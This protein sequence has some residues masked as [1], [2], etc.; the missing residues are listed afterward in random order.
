[1]IQLRWSN[2]SEDGR[3]SYVM[4]KTDKVRDLVLIRQ[5]RDILDEYDGEHGKDDYIFPFL[6]NK[7]PWARYSTPSMKKRMPIDTMKLMYNKI[8]AVNALLNKYLGKLAKMADIDKKV[9]F[10]VSRHS[11]AYQALQDDIDPMTIKG[12]L[13]HGSLLTTETY[14]KDFEIQELDN[15]LQRMFD[16]Q[17]VKDKALKLLRSLSPEDR[18][19][20]IRLCQETDEKGN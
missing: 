9:S 2:V 4:D 5:V 20:V 19:E 6:D 16:K 14:L 1:M 18:E 17:S 15:T 13:A 3:I 12:A 10:H 8:G 7:A 11:F